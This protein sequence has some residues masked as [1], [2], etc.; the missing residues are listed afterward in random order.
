[1]GGSTHRP[2][3]GRSDE[4]V[5]VGE[6]WCRRPRGHAYLAEDIAD[7][8]FHRPLAHEQLARDDLVGLAGREQAQHLELP[9]RKTVRER[10]R[11]RCTARGARAGLGQGEVALRSELLEDLARGS[12]LELGALVVA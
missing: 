9:F 5:L 7:M 4:A 1:M 2:K 10:W 11:R 8:T 12:A 6:G 3:A